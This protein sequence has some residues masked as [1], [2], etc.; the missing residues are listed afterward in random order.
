MTNS[1][2][3]IG[4][5]L[6]LETDLDDA[7]TK[8]EAALKTEG[9]GILTQIDV[10]QTLK[11]KIDVDFRPYRILGACNPPLAHRALMAAPDVGLLLPCNV[12]VDEVDDNRTEVS[13]VDPL[14][15]ADFS[16]SERLQAVAAEAKS[17]LDRVAD[18]LEEK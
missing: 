8:V 17:K 1:T 3:N 10:K 16:D 13:I 7:L 18:I 14:M 15:M 6:V 2:E 11:K 12:T 9:F 4:R 5:H